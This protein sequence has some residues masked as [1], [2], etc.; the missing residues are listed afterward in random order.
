MESQQVILAVIVTVR[1]VIVHAQ[2]VPLAWFKLI[3]LLAINFIY[4][5]YENITPF[6]YDHQDSCDE[7]S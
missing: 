7:D 5:T 1:V 2:P 4:I 6:I 3:Q